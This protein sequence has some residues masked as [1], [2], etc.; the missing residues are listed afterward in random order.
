M[1]KKPVDSSVRP[2]AVALPYAGLNQTQIARQRNISRHCVENAIKK[3]KKTGQYNDFLRTG[4]PKRIPSCGVRH[5]K[6]L[7]KDDRR[8]S[9][10]KITSDVNASLPK[11]VSTRTVRRYLRDHGYEYVFKIKTMTQ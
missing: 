9:A 5:L 1:G 4:R 8:I 10:A 6:R 7:V 3:Y 11:P 2:Q